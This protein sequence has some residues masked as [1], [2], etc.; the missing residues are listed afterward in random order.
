MA[1]KAQ[2]LGAHGRSRSRQRVLQCTTAAIGALIVA[3]CGSTAAPSANAGGHH[4]KAT[5]TS[6]AKVDLHFTITNGTTGPVK[7]WTLRC[8][9]PGGTHPDPAA[10]CQ[11]LLSVK[12]PFA[13]QSSVKMMCPMVLASSRRAII[14]GTY[15]GHKVDEQLVDG[16][17]DM[18]HWGKLKKLF[19]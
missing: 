2:T 13:D 7:H 4:N 19:N 11:T 17:C 8:N 3:G 16:G 5:E 9:P 1:M 6:A 15:Y 18:I 10:A 12:N 14:T